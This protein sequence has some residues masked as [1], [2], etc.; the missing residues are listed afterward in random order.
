MSPWADLTCSGDSMHTRAAV[1]IMVTRVGLLDMARQYLG[2][3]DPTDPLA[4]PVFGNLGDLPP[5]LALVG[6]DEVLLDDSVRVVTR[7]GTSGT[8]AQLYVAAGMQ[9][10]WP[11]W[12]GALPEADAAMQMIGDW[13]DARLV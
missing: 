1:D 5:I 10:V 11:T 7:A 8:D 4:S 13:I 6:G 2:D 9:H 12:C 3:H